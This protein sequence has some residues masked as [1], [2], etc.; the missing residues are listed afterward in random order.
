MCAFEDPDA[1]LPTDLG[2]KASG[3]KSLRARGS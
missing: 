3:P 1:F 2:R